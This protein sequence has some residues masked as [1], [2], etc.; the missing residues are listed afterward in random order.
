MKLKS[1][2]MKLSVA[3]MSLLLTVQNPVQAFAAAGTTGSTYLS[4]LFLS[5]AKS[6]SDEDIAAAKQYLT[7]KG[8]T[9]LDQDLTEGGDAA[10]SKKRPVFLGYKTT[11]DPDNAIRDLRVLP[12]S[13]D[14]NFYESYEELLESQKDSTA[15]FLEDVKAALKE[16]RE[17]RKKKTAKGEIAFQA[18][19]KLYDP[20]EEQPLGNLLENTTQEEEGMRRGLWRTGHA[21]MTLIL[22]TGNS[23]AVKA[24]MQNLA[25][26]ADSADNTWID[27]LQEIKLSAMQERYETDNPG[28]AA[29][30]I[31]RM[32]MA[33]YDADA[34]IL[35]GQIAD[36]N[37]MLKAY[38][39]SG[40]HFDDAGFTEESADAYF[41]AHPDENQTAWARA[42]QLEALLK[43]CTYGD[44]TM[45]SF[46]TGK[47]RDFLNNQGDR[48]EL[49]PFLE[50]FSPA[51][52]RL[53]SYTTMEQLFITGLLDEQGW[54][55]TYDSF[56]ELIENTPQMSIYEGVNRSVVDSCS[57]ALTGDAFD[58][59]QSTGVQALNP[60]LFG[61]GMSFAA[62]IVL[63]G[64]LA[65]GAAGVTMMV[66]SGMFNSTV[67]TALN[68]QLSLV[69][70]LK[71]NLLNQWETKLANF[72][73]Q[74]NL[75]E[76]VYGSADNAL[77]IFFG[78]QNAYDSST[79]FLTSVSDPNTAERFVTAMKNNG[80]LTE[81]EASQLLTQIE[82]RIDAE[83]DRT[84]MAG[85]EIAEAKAQLSRKWMGYLGLGV[86]LI[87][88]IILVGSGIIAAIE[89]SQYYE[90]GHYIPLPEFVVDT[91]KNTNGH[92]FY[93]YYDGV[94]CNRADQEA[95]YNEMAYGRMGNIGDL[96][97][98]VGKEWVALYYTKDSSAGSPIRADFRIGKGEA[99]K[100]IPL[101][102]HALAL[103]GEENAFNLTND[104]YSYNDDLNGLYLFYSTESAI[105]GSVFSNGI[106][107][108]TATISLALGAAAGCL[109][110]V[111]SHKRKKEQAA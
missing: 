71:Q 37:N 15:I 20:D 69:S 11:S 57:I 103:F 42:G 76:K 86:C 101:G 12:M 91:A 78:Q 110:T 28:R 29:S 90:G 34:Q 67:Y 43:T 98:D 84:G 2:L 50:A 13:G 10:F 82:K 68:A 83:I 52:R 41:E 97:G 92:I 25:F 63:A 14:Y 23:Y 8:Y 21:N 111:F 19:S 107:A 51:Q 62:P 56:T 85:T 7:D 72:F 22:M 66:K 75:M 35:A 47:D 27:R 9:L 31:Q 32:M 74:P 1:L 58:R 102:K 17:N 3:A 55:D 95:M 33:D 105:A 24:M 104:K 64:S 26:A 46:M 16:Y 61:T 80:T 36:M 30:E 99:G 79:A 106:I 77:Q 96:N 5:Y 39:S 54:E 89:M 38:D 59:Q 60:G 88:A 40:I 4:D 81:K 108:T 93:T 45:Y 87:A 49:Y 53:L 109:L 94:K 65:V 100:K 6:G 48:M 70:N 73:R 44:G 18:L